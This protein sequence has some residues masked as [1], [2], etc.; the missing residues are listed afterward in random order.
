MKNKT[1]NIIMLIL[2]FVISNVASYYLGC[3][4]SI[5]IEQIGNPPLIQ[6]IKLK[7]NFELYIGYNEYDT[8]IIDEISL[9]KNQN[10]I[11]YERFNQKFT[12]LT[13]LRNI[14]S[15][16]IYT[17]YNNSGIKINVKKITKNKIISTY[18]DNNGKIIKSF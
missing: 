11:M 13:I 16:K 6:K 5:K 1:T 10:Q 7:N 17:T 14:P 9:W 8:S 4:N 12:Q 18:F 3:K 2:L 15:G